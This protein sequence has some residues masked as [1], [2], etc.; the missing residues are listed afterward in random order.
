MERYILT[1]ALKPPTG[2][3][4]ICKRRNKNN[5]VLGFYGAQGIGG[6]VMRGI[7][8]GAGLMCSSLL[9]THQVNAQTVI[10]PYVKSGGNWV[11]LVTYYAEEPNFGGVSGRIHIAHVYK[12]DWD[13]FSKIVGGGSY[14]QADCNIVQFNFRTVANDTST[15]DISGSNKL[16]FEGNVMATEYEDENTKPTSITAPAGTT[17]GYLIIRDGKD[18]PTLSA[19]AVVFDTVTGMFFYQAGVNLTPKYN[20]VPSSDLG[21]TGYGGVQ[22]KVTFQGEDFATTSIYYIP[23][24]ADNMLWFDG[25]APQGEGYIN[26]ST[27]YN[28]KGESVKTSASSIEVKCLALV[29]IR[30]FFTDSEWTS[31]GNSGGT[32]L[33]YDRLKD[34][35]V[36][37]YGIMYQGEVYTNMGR[38]FNAFAPLK[39]YELSTLNYQQWNLVTIPFPDIG[40]IID[41]PDFPDLGF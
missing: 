27:T 33:V 17:D 16:G 37:H 2:E 14:A 31:I 40:D 18:A 3:R 5:P 4:D 7:V 15:M 22:A 39:V 28:R 20:A 36:Y 30:Y 11:S 35:A 21:S 13:G 34:A 1:D 29:P 26:L 8:V 24:T 6:I 12:N 32:A 10:I 41:I 25:L 19:S 23:G 9:F 38:I